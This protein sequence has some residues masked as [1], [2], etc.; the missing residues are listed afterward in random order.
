MAHVT[1]PDTPRRPRADV[2][3]R[4][5]GRTGVLVDLRTS[6]IFELNNTAARVWELLGASLT[7]NQI[8]TS[9]SRE[10]SVDES[11]LGR[12]P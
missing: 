9:L 5:M 1:S 11:A 3:A 8:V 10:Y 2:V 4:R 12:E 7:P 6:R